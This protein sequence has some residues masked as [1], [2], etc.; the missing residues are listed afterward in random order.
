ML[1]D[2]CRNTKDAAQSYVRCVLLLTR[3]RFP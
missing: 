1:F 3:V 2:W